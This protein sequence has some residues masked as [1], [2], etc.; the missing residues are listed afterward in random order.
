VDGKWMELAQYCD[1]WLSL[2]LAVLNLTVSVN[3]EMT[4]Y[5]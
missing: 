1:Q 2:I 5:D 4:V 3:I